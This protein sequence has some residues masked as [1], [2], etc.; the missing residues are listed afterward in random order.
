MRSD[1][2]P[3]ADFNT[4]RP[5]SLYRP[6]LSN[7]MLSLMVLMMY[8]PISSQTSAP[9]NAPIDTSNCFLISFL[10]HMFPLLSCR[11]VLLECI[12]VSYS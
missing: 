9:S 7:F 8:R 6:M 1:S 12:I 2:L 5:S 11:M 3:V 10:V 4:A